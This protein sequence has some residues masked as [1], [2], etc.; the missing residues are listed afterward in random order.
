MNKK[1]Q[2][3][4]IIIPGA[5]KSG[6]NTLF[7]ILSS[8][9]GVTNPRIK[10]T[11]FFAL[12]KETILE[13]LNWYKNLFPDKDK[14]ILD[15]STFYFSSK[16]AP[17][18]IKK[19]ITEP[20]IIIILRDP[21]KRAYSGFLQMKKR[22]PSEDKRTFQEII[23][24]I[25]GPQKE[26]ITLTE[27]NSLKKAIKENE[28]NNNFLNEDYLKKEYRAPFKSYFEDSLWS[29]KYFQES[30][31][32]ERI[33]R[34]KKYF[35]GNNVKIVFLEKLIKRPE[36][37]IKEIL[38]FLNLEPE[39]KVLKLP[40]SY[41]TKVPKNKKSRKLLKNLKKSPLIYRTAK[42]LRKIGFGKIVDLIKSPLY[43]PKPSLP[44]KD[45]QQAKKIL[46]KECSFWINKNKELEN[47]WKY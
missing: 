44:K 6:T 32:K 20:K 14:F 36:L 26:K 3:K 24:Q 41:K 30:L 31:Y 13:N 19:F 5:Q 1:I 33:D 2:R 21:A 47:L 18:F 15:A 42:N 35:E 46:K 38:N 43:K 25:E 17:V 12:E 40:H 11:E 27:N 23:S 10:E 9:S 34:Y 4:A 16:R 22:V 7:E 39:K 29:Y 45:Y 37:T 28:I 8:H